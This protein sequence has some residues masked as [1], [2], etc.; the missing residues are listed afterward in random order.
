MMR[1]IPAIILTFF[2]INAFA[3]T[4]A[5]SAGRQLLQAPEAAQVPNVLRVS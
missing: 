2:M 1:P 3:I 4:S 5:D